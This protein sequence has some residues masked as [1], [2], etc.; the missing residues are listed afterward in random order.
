[1]GG[2]D[3]N[4]AMIKV[5]SSVRKSLKW[6]TKIAFH[7]MEEAIFNSYIVYNKVIGNQRFMQFKLALIRQLIG[8]A[9]PVEK[10]YSIPTVGKHYLELIPATAKK[11]AHRRDAW[12]AQRAAKEKKAGINVRTAN[13]TPDSVQLLALKCIIQSN[14]NND[15]VFNTY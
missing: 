7:F 10:L 14:L 15:N 8:K 12:Y 9:L 11:R 1:M 13:N 5:Y 4:D 6:T 3:H 2:V